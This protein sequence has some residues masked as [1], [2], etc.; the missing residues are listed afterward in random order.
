MTEEIGGLDEI[1]RAAVREMPDP[2][3]PSALRTL[4]RASYGS[5]TGKS[6]VGLALLGGV[7]LIAIGVLG[8]RE[9]P[10]DVVVAIL[11]MVF[12]IFF[13][14]AP[15]LPARRASR[16][17]QGGVRAL[18]EV[19]EVELRAPGPG[20]TI[21]ALK[22]GFA[23]G[24]WRVFHPVGTFDAKFETDA[25]WATDLRAGSKVLVLVDPD[26]QRVGVHLGPEDDETLPG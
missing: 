5:L 7:P 13:L 11:G 16:A 21:D 12:M 23:S 1:V 2:P 10:V 18:A 26:R 20:R 17:Q 4:L 8:S 25:T 15:A 9:E 6:M 3:R 24:T 14:V 19:V 22:S